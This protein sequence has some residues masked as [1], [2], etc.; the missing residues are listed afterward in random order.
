[1]RTR[2]KN[3]EY[4]K[5]YRA[6]HP[7][8]KVRHRLE[9]KK[10]ANNN[11]KKI[12]AQQFIRTHIEESPLGN[13][14][15]FCG[16]SETLEHGHIDYNYPDLYLTVCHQCNCWMG[17][18]GILDLKDT[19]WISIGHKLVARF[20]IIKGASKDINCATCEHQIKKGQRYKEL[21]EPF[22]LLESTK[23]HLEC[24]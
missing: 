2:E 1:M 14:C 9:Q 24:G 7:Q 19:E 20:H 18:E 8:C 5:T 17:K 12:K 16:T 13:E 23:H 21:R 4:M 10:Y 22:S 3:Q 15:E 11:P 6:S